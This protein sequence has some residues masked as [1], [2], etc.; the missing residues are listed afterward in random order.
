MNT[1]SRRRDWQGKALHFAYLLSALWCVR[2]EQIIGQYGW[3][4]EQLEDNLGTGDWKGRLGQD[5]AEP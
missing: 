3:K 5:S 2:E 4:A 1:I